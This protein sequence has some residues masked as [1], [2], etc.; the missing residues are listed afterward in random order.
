MGFCTFLSSL[1]NCLLKFVLSIKLLGEVQNFL[2][3]VLKI[4]GEVQSYPREG[5][6]HP[7]RSGLMK[8]RFGYLLRLY[9]ILTANT[10]IVG[11]LET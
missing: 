11:R 2:R 1:Y 8:V 5:A 4:S 3:E 7:P 6:H 9:A 10:D